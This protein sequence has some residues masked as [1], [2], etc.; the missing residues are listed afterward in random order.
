MAQL[1]GK[2]ALVTGGAHRLGRAIVLQLAA[3]GAAIS[4]HY[5]TSGAAAHA[6]AADVRD[7]YERDVL[8][9]Q[10]DLRD[11]ANATTVVDATIAHYGHLDILV[12]SAGIWGKTPTGETTPDDWDAM[13]HVNA[14]TPYLL[15]QHAAPY[16]TAR[17]GSVVAITDV[18]ITGAWSNYAAYLASKAALDQSM[19]VLARDLA[20]AVRV[21]TVAPGA[22]LPPSDWDADQQHAIAK[23]NLLER[24]GTAEDVA[25]AVLYLVTAP[26]VNGVMLPVDGGER[27]K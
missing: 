7:Q 15:A 24:W 21:N 20:P 3:A 9:V 4:L 23:R 6:T 18:G 11:P 27:L 16:L 2:V 19:R 14:R 12:L 25:G 13:M 17:N 22:V 26:F 10:A 8:L 5:G 1:D